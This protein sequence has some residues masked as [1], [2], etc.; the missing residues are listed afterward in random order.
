MNFLADSDLS[1]IKVIRK[2]SLV[3]GTFGLGYKSHQHAVGLFV[4][5]IEYLLLDVTGDLELEYST[6]VEGRGNSMVA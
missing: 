5:Q 1:C 4:E 3:F 2:S 6:T